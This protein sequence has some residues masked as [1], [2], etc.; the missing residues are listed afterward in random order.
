MCCRF[1]DSVL[2]LPATL[3]IIYILFANQWLRSISFFVKIVLFQSV[4]RQKVQF[5]W[6]N[7]IIKLSKKTRKGLK[8]KL[9]GYKA[10]ELLRLEASHES[11][12]Y[13]AVFSK[14]S[15]HR[16]QNLRKVRWVFSYLS[17]MLG[18]SSQAR[19]IENV[20]ANFVAS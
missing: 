18:I 4:E 10:I 6:I 5:L 8:A 13:L 2:F 9:S 3:L 7:R 15:L 19:F 12:S 14:V 20:G 16:L 11:F 1:W 17:S